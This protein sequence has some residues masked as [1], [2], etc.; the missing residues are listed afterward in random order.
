[1]VLTAD[2]KALKDAQIK[3]LPTIQKLIEADG[4]IF[5]ELGVLEQGQQSIN[6]RLDRGG[7]RMDG[8]EAEV[9]NLKELM[10]KYFDRAETRHNELKGEIQNGKI[11]E[12]RNEIKDRQKE[13]DKRNAFKRGLYIGLI[14]LAVGTVLAVLGTLFMK[15]YG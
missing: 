7:K 9:K 15:V 2:E 3:Q 11:Q 5:H 10:T 14:T 8:I 13:E 6:T 4:K 1:M 12:L